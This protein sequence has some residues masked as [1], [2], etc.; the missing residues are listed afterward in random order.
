[1]LPLCNTD[2]FIFIFIHIKLAFVRI[3]V[4]LKNIL[5]SCNVFTFHN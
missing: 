4:Y 3:R 1:M 2:L 5:A